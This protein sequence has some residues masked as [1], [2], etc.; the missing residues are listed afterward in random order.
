MNSWCSDA[1]YASLCYWD[2]ATKHWLQVN[3]TAC[4]PGDEAVSTIVRDGRAVDD[5]RRA[6]RISG[7]PSEEELVETVVEFE[8]VETVINGLKAIV[9]A[10][11]EN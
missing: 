2:G 8:E 7:S 5:R 3:D 9:L 4:P 1:G 11:K 6:L 10:P